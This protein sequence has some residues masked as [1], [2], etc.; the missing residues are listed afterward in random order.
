MPPRCPT[1]YHRKR[2]V[3]RRRQRRQSRSP[4]RSRSAIFEVAP[5]GRLIAIL[6]ADPQTPGEKQQKEDKA[7]AVWVDHDLHGKRLYLLDAESGK[8]D[9]V[10]L[11]PDVTAVSWNK[12]GDRLIAS[13]EGPNHVSD[14]GPETQTWLVRR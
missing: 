3:T 13:I 10:A 9:P 11:P 5:A 2:L 1:R 6:A 4:C 12:S 7:D 14:L 8:L